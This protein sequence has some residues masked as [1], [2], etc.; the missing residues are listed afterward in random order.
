MGL[1]LSLNNRS[2]IEVASQAA[3][4]AGSL[5]LQHIHGKRQLSYKEGRANFVTDVDVLVE[6]KVIALLRAEYPDYNILSEE[7]EAIDNKSEYT[8]VIDP[9]DGTNNYVHG[10]PF[11]SVSI[12]L[13]SS[14]DIVLGVVYDPWMK[15]IFTAELGGGTHLNGQPVAVSSQN[16]AKGAF[17]GT[18]TGYDVEAGVR[19]L[20]TIKSNWSDMGGIRLMGSAVLGL[21]YVAC[22]RLDLYVHSYLY[23]WDI[24][25]GI[26]LVREAGGIVTDWERKPANIECRQILAGNSTVHE[27]FMELMKNQLQL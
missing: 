26:L 6:K 19:M 2:A 21:A 4:L 8:W 7:A 23:P 27:E 20:D 24:A 16:S 9:L 11:Y 1:P 10:V 18:D 22:G 3:K 14:E 13:K 5:L 15:E 12:A 25:A 17:I